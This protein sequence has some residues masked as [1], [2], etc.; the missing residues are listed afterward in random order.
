VD[1]AVTLDDVR[2][3]AKRIAPYVHRTPIVTCRSIDERAGRTVFLK[4][5]NL[6]RVGA[7]KLRGAMNAVLA[8]PE[9]ERARGVVT[10][11]SGNHGQALALAARVAG[12]PAHVVVPRGAPAVKVAAIEGYG[13][14]IVACEPTLAAREES[15]RA[16][17]EATGATLIPPYDHPHV[18]AGQG[19]VALEILEQVAELD[20]IVAPVG[21]G[22][23]I[24]GIATVLAALRPSVRAVGA[25]PAGADDAARSK[26]AGERLPQLDPRTI[27]DGLR[28]SLGELTWPIVRDRVSTI[29]T[30][31]DAEIVGAMRL[32]F[33]RAKLVVEPSG[34][35]SLAAALGRDLRGARVACVLS[36]GN[37][38]L[39][40]LP[41]GA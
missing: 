27:A 21:G 41:F 25:E 37:V 7:F 17:T 22:G 31:D 28:T 32:C 18:I 5:E 3:A 16:V 10:H 35:V 19:T 14:H 38:D 4:C 11:S 13:A 6:Q 15:A 39:A 9:A 36:G 2:A 8:L 29:V 1:T 23:L 26:A 20:A 34:A 30:V 40:S 24:S 33:E 12:I